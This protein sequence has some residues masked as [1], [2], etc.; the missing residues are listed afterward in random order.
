MAAHAAIV[1]V[2]RAVVAEQMGFELVVRIVA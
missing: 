1:T 2:R